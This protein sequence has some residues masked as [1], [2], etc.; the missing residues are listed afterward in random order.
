MSQPGNDFSTEPPSK[1][2]G[3]D[4]STV[5]MPKQGQ[6]E[7]SASSPNSESIPP[8][9]GRYRVVSLLGRGGFGA[10]YQTQYS[11]SSRRSVRSTKGMMTCPI[12]PF[13]FSIEQ[14]T[15]P[16][17]NVGCR[18]GRSPEHCVDP[19]AE[20][21]KHQLRILPQ[22]VRFEVLHCTSD[23]WHEHLLAAFPGETSMLPQCESW[24]HF[25]AR[26]I[27]RRLCA[28]LTGTLASSTTVRPMRKI[29]AA[30][31]H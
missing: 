18:I 23:K 22:G 8:S 31:W 13:V 20:N 25:T 30:G 12:R 5:P 14:P 21:W 6:S 26:E 7:S 2:L 9:F 4:G 11:N 10:V 16:S 24:K 17:S 27:N 28:Y 15:M 19:S 3:F 29:L 1:I